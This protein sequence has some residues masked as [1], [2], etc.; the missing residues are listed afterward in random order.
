LVALL[1]VALCVCISIV[2]EEGMMLSESRHAQST[3][4]AAAMAGACIL[5]QNYKTTQ[6]IDPASVTQ[7]QLIASFNGYANDAIPAS[8]N[9]DTTTVNAYNPPISGPFLGKAGYVEVTVQY[10]Q[11][12]YFS[13]VLSMWPINA[14][15][16]NT[17]P[18]TA[19]AV[20]EG[21]WTP[22]HAGV[23][24]LNYQGSDLQST[25]NGTLQING[26]DFI[27]DS[28]SA[29]A[30]FNQGNA[31]VVVNNGT[32]D[33]TGNDVNAISSTGTVGSGAAI[34]TPN[35]PS[36]V[37]INQHPTPDPLAYLPRPGTTI[38][39]GTGQQQPPGIPPKAPQPQQVTLPSGQQAWLMWPGSY[40]TNTGNDTFLPPD[41]NG[42]LIVMMQANNSKQGSTDGIYYIANGGFKYN[43]TS[44]VTDTQL[45]INNPAGQSWNGPLDY[46]GST[47]GMMIYMGPNATNGINLQGNPSSLVYL[48]PLT[49]PSP[50]SGMIYWQ[51]PSNTSDVQIAGN[52]SFTING[53]FYSPTALMKVT[54]NG[55]T[56]TGSLGQQI[57]GSQVGSQ[58][59]A[60]DLKLD[61]NGS[62]IVNYQ[63]PP[64][65]PIRILTLV[66]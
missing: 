34:Q 65:Q 33:I 2:L 57:A 19:R 26:G 5:Y 66:E 48:L 31:T 30:L 54:G 52:G 14:T 9:P 4:D 15:L 55:G 22:F 36:D 21:M 42:G 11:G 3:A 7:A 60:A 38:P 25:G 44:I 16:S 1:M 18:I 43:N 64:K 56:Y 10:N 23:L 63:G 8:P 35:G 59:V 40:N 24:L 41:N 13:W 61:G 20:A 28:N 49:D 51:D 27:I 37:Y 17:M 58:Y 50:Y 12:R 6:G 32:V 47:G 29:A 62:V 45:L 46:Q 39:G 53:T